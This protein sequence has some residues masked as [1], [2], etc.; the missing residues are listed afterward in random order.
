MKSIEEQIRKA[1]EEGQF[2]NLKGKGKP[3]NLDHNPYADPNWN[4][5]H[6]VIK[7]GGFTL[8][9]IETRQE[10]DTETEAL[11]IALQRAW[12]W[13]QEALE[14]KL[15]VDLVDTEWQRALSVFNTRVE[16]L[17]KKIR[18]YN[19]EVP[20]DQFQVFTLQADRIIERITHQS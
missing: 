11:Q 14:R 18:S 4:L 20:A 15:P 13:R 12:E 17:N 19:L 5:A 7:S 2:K 3:L 8:P 1:M 6:H 10:I 16:Q 9:W